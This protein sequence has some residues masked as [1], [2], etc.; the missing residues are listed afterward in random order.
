[1]RNTVLLVAISSVLLPLYADRIALHR[2]DELKGEVVSFRDGVFRLADGREVAVDE[3]KSVTLDTAEQE[4]KKETVSGDVKKLLDMA[5]EARKK[6]PNAKYIVLVDWGR[7]ELNRDGSRS[8]E[9]HGVVLLCK[10]EALGL[11]N[12]SLYFEEGRSKVEI[13]TARSIAPDGKTYDY[14]PNKVKIESPARETIYYDYGKYLVYTI[15]KVQVGS[16][17]EYRYRSLTYKP[18]DKKMW[19]PDWWFGGKEPVVWSYIEIVFPNNVKLYYKTYDMDE[20]SAKP[21]VLVGK[22]KTKYIWEY[23]DFPGIVEE[24]FMPDISDVVPRLRCSTFNRWVYLNQWA[25]ERLKKNMKV[26]D[27]LKRRATEI[28]YGAKTDEERVAKIYHWV[29]RN[30]RYI[31]IKGSIMSGMCGHPAWETLKK[32]YGDCVDVAVLMSTLL[33]A[34][35]VEAYPVW[36]QTNDSEAFIDL[37]NFVGNHA[38]VQVKLRDYFI[39]DPTATDYRYPYY[40]DDDQ[41]TYIYNPIRGVIE[42]TPVPPPEDN[43]RNMQTEVRIHPDLTATLEQ[44]NTYTGCWES[45][46]RGWFRRTPKKEHQKLML[47]IANRHY[48]G[49]KVLNLRLE[50][51]E[52]LS[53]EFRWH[54]RLKLAGFGTKA[55]DF[56][57]FGMPGV[58]YDFPEIALRE[59]RYDIHYNYQTDNASS[60]AFKHTIIVTIPEGWRVY[61]LPDEIKLE[62][63]YADYTAKYSLIDGGRKILFEDRFRRRVR[64]IPVEDYKEYKRFLESTSAY[65]KKKVFLI[66]EKKR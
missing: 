64:K 40:R 9:Y 56:F 48:P 19:F 52:D 44:L 66:K 31:S 37:P 29:Q 11:A 13:I 25:T 14:D 61:Y 51:I 18:F 12:R 2:G 30:I 36:I 62:C 49:S 23:R 35:G 38:V 26:T 53:K 24:P 15:P 50:N 33:R 59:R 16:I 57:I 63:T 45:W 41:G 10:R 55:G 60:Y 28:V 39:L 54:Y 6:Y 8:Y 21:Q 1:M 20:K 7:Y 34:V 42:P 58:D 43:M 17:I 5:T 47:S 65:S 4:A 32:G 22:N 27:E 3:V 46:V